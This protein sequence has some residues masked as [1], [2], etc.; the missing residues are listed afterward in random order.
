MLT[1]AECHKVREEEVPARQSGGLKLIWQI[2][3]GFSRPAKFHLGFKEA[4]RERFKG[5]SKRNSKEDWFSK[6]IWEKIKGF[7]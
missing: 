7:C 5:S 3:H 2:V 6:T 4:E 1:N